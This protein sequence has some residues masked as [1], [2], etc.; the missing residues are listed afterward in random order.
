MLAGLPLS[1]GFASIALIAA[2]VMLLVGLGASF[3]HL[4]R[5]ER[6]WRAVLM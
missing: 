5:P 1:P 4:G 6:A 3:G 2:E